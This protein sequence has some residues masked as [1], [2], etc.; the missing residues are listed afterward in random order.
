MNKKK[1]AKPSTSN[2]SD[3]AQFAVPENSP[4]SGEGIAQHLVEHAFSDVV[5]ESFRA[6][7]NEALDELGEKVFDQA[8]I[9]KEI[10]ILRD[11]LK[12]LLV[13]SIHSAFEIGS[14]DAEDE[15][16]I[17]VFLRDVEVTKLYF[18]QWFV[19]EYYVPRNGLAKN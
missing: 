5:D 1:S 9:E 13:N 6:S 19:S 17:R 7:I 10:R 16:V 4:K 12:Y 15:L 11:F 14:E 2:L 18:Y 3:D 8:R